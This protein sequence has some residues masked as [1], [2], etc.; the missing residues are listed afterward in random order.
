MKTKNEKTAEKKSFDE[1]DQSHPAQLSL[2]ELILPDE[3]ALSNTVELYDFMPKYVWGKLE[4]IEGRFLDSLRRDFQCR[5]VNYKLKID[6]AKIE[7]KD[8]IDRDYF[9]G[10]REELVEDALRKLMAERGGLYLDE[11]AGILFSIYE[12]QQELAQ[13]GHTYSSAELKD[14]LRVLKK[15][16]LELKTENEK[17]GV[18]FS[19]IESLGFKGEE[20][21]TRTFVRFSPLFTQS[22]N[23]GRFRRINYEKVMSYKN[24][25]A[26]QLH[27]RMSHHYTQAGLT[28]PYTISLST[29]IR[30]FGLTK[31]KRLDLNLRDVKNALQEMCEK[32]VLLEW[33]EEKVL[34]GKKRF[35]MVEVVLI[36]VPHP[37]F[38]W[39]VVN[40]NKKQK[41]RQISES[42]SP[43]KIKS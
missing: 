13:N 20:G 6:P 21:E 16:N 37:S 10:K 23:E 42:K 38:V 32:E 29:I 28:S 7:C 2:F 22:I 4:R 19:P 5:G 25:I 11:Q 34:E 35:K 33:N 18:L 39:E 36:L 12:L 1:Y 26:R 17:T 3:R 43:S 31:Y 8:G 41:E 15:T 24:V 40:A 14:A 30:D 27:K 9:P